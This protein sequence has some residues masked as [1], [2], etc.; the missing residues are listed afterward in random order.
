MSEKKM[1]SRNVAIALGIICILLV[2]V[3]AYFS[4]TGISAQ[5]SYNNLQNQN[6]QLQTWL[7]GNISSFET[8][9]SSLN[10]NITNLETWLS[11]NITAYNNYSD[12]HSHTNVEYQNLTTTIVNLE[13]QTTNLQ[14][15]LD[16]DQSIVE[17][18]NVT[19]SQAPDNYTSWYLYATWAGYIS[20]KIS[21]ANVSLYY[22]NL[23]YSFH[24]V[25]QYN[26]RPLDFGPSDTVNFLVPSFSYLY[27]TVGNNN[28]VD[29][30]T[31]TVTITYYY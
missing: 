8:Q 17:V 11:G 3:I 22:A 20:I 21:N 18:N 23:V 10:A 13:Q 2:A 27:I 28:P 12:E 4:I 14:N 9:V 16:S 26:A 1:V 30:A 5:N 29:V 31:E 15:I 25:Y 19:V 24:G 6:K 7:D